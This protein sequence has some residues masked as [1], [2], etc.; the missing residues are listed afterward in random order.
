M[1][2]SNITVNVNCNWGRKG[3]CL[4]QVNSGSKPD[5]AISLAPH[6][7]ILDAG[8]P[9]ISSHLSLTKSKVLIFSIT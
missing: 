8:F 5:Y 7:G 1:P 4:S 9:P 2:E 6:P 3:T